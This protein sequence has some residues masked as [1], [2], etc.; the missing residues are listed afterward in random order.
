MTTPTMDAKTLQETGKNLVKASEGGDP[1]STLLALLQPLQKFT[2][3]EDLLRQSKIGVAVNKLR[4]NKDPKVAQVAGQLINKWKMDV[5]GK[6][7]GKQ[8][9][10]S[11]AAAAGGKGGVNGRDGT[12]SPAPNGASVKTE[13]VK[14][15]KE[16]ARKST[17]PPEKRDFKLDDVDTKVTGDAV[18]DGCIGLI[19]NG[20]AYL[21]PEAPDEILAVARSVEVAGF[22]AHKSETSAAYKSKMRSLFQNLKM[23]GNADLRR[24]VFT[25]AIQ[26]KKF[27]TMTSDELKSAE[28]RASD[29]ALEKENMSKAM[30]AQE[31]KA[32]STTYVFH[33]LFFHLLPAAARLDTRERETSRPHPSVLPEG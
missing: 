25:G 2:A 8:G 27:V 24:D 29:A 14:K 15:E 11:P 30:T 22:E 28:K 12:S 18:R 7:A 3:T 17:V 9:S 23:K 1:A 19:Y 20:L 31:E 21:S 6:N 26:P 16:G 10:G 33:P 32:I 13:G 4:Q 5:K